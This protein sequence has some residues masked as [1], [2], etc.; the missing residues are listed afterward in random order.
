MPA[1]DGMAGS[2]MDEWKAPRPR[3]ALWYYLAVWASGGL[4]I[5]VWLYL[6]LRDINR[7]AKT[8]IINATA[9]VGTLVG[10]VVFN[11]ALIVY[12]VYRNFGFG[13]PRWFVPTILTVGLGA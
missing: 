3:S 10:L 5:F 7:L 1:P 11:Q 6:L 12:A 9:L 2:E 8:R 13:E 4:F